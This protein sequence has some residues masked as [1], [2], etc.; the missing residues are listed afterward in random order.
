MSNQTNVGWSVKTR[1]PS[2]SDVAAKWALSSSEH[3]RSQTGSTWWWTAL[4]KIQS[5][6]QGLIEEAEHRG[7]QLS[8]KE[9]KTA[10]L[11]V[12]KIHIQFIETIIEDQIWDIENKVLHEYSQS[13]MKII[14]FQFLCNM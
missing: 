14:K 10:P 1:T 6:S 7:K 12:R 2:P 8:E 13:W 3:F 5:Y 9:T 11:K 4:T